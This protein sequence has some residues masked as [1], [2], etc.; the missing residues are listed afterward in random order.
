MGNSKDKNLTCNYC[1]KNGH[2]RS[3]CWFR[4]KKQPDANI[5]ELAEGMKNSA[6]VYL[7]QTDRLVIKI[8]GS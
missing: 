7:L 5:T 1:H 6:T 4:K 8:D 3:E 2:I